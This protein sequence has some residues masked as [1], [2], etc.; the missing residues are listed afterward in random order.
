M[1][2]AEK[3]KTQLI[4]ELTA[5]RQQLALAQ[6]KHPP[7]RHPV[8]KTEHLEQLRAIYYL[9]NMISRSRTMTDIYDNALNAVR[10]TMQTDAVA[11]SVFEAGQA[12]FV[13]WKG[14]S[15][16]FRFKAA[17]CLP[18]SPVEVFPTPLFIPNVQRAPIT[19]QL[20]TIII[21]EGLR[22]I[23]FL[24]LINQEKLL[25]HFII[26]YKKTHQFDETELWLTQMIADQVAFAVER[27]RAED[28]L[29]QSESMYRTLVRNFP[30]TTTF[31]FDHDLRY[32]LAEGTSLFGET[33]SVT[34]KTLWDVLPLE[35]G[36]ALIPHCQAAL[37][38]EKNMIEARTQDRFYEAHTLP[39]SDENKN[40]LMGM[41]VIWD[42]TVRKLAEIEQKHLEEK[43]FD[44][45]RKFLSL[46]YSGATIASSLNIQFVLNTFSK[47]MVS[48]LSVQGCVISEWTPETDKI[49][50][51]ARY[52]P[53]GWWPERDVGKEYD[54]TDIALTKW[55]LVER[56]AEYL[57]A[58]QIDIDPTD[59]AYMKAN[60]IKSLL[61]LPME[62]QDRVVGLVEV[63]DDQVEHNFTTEDIAF[64]QLL[65]NQAAT[66]LENARLYTQARNEI[67]ERR[68]A[69]RLLRQVTARNQVI[70]NAIPDSLF[71]FSR[72]RQLLDY[73]VVDN[74][75]LHLDI[76]QKNIIGQNL[77]DILHVPKDMV[78]TVLRYV[79]KTLSSRRVQI[80]EYQ[81][82][83][84][85]DELDF[86]VRLVASQEDELLAIVRNITKKKRAER[87]L[88]RAER[89][90]AL[91]Q[92]AAALAHE[93]NNPL[94][95]IQSNL[96]LMLKYP[97]AAQ[98]GEEYLHV[99]H[100]QIERVT[101]ITRQ[102]LNFARPQAS[103]RQ[104]VP[105]IDQIEQILVLVSKRLE[106]GG[107]QIVVDAQPNLP[108]VLVSTQQLNQVFLNLLINA[109]EAATEPLQLHIAIYLDN[110]DVVTSFTSD[111][112]IIPP[113][114][115]PHIFEP[116]F[117]TKLEGSGLGLWIS[118]SLIEQ[119]G[120]S[121]TAENLTND[122][123]VV[124]TVRLPAAT[125]LA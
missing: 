23:G 89:L 64:T 94:Q 111:G 83:D 106:N 45:N 118:H 50:V 105:V 74:D 51:V 61:M 77:S 57:T 108:H 107:I 3:S 47:E 93:I 78:A 101:T 37:A 43:A 35:I 26:A 121:L 90:A 40:V 21:D 12:S 25:G 86:E 6:S 44:L 84:L 95:A 71:F 46:Q 99:I 96:D 82:P 113:E 41:V 32:L 98:E 114:I 75:A 123:G 49:S 30:G 66:A 17:T 4:E 65:A 122:R 28:T 125:P 62:V 100:R 119:N 24:P 56:R 16:E 52:G 33:L 69:E 104:Y 60:Y 13:A 102:V 42:I 63:M 115:L 9:G 68:E 5:V 67:I 11:L 76:L 2:D 31:L 14:L 18:W 36:E 120:G 22:A 116:F 59:L 1:N 103:H 73:K 15:E 19:P 92:L 29:R 8:Q 58:N 87:Q 48:L 27:K 55:V 85:F 20:R 39:V 10:I 117:T 79:D 80:F 91:G 34:G 112:P 109:I 70:L 110:D 124:F 72:D 88:V 97:L 38:G 54:L 81:I 7:H 53:E